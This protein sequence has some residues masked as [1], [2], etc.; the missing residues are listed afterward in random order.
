[1][2]T[3]AYWTAVNRIWSTAT[4]TGP[5]EKTDYIAVYR[6]GVRCY[7]M[8]SNVRHNRR[9]EE[10]GVLLWHT[11]P[12]HTYHAVPLPCCSAK[13]LDC[14]FPIWFT[15]CGRVWFTNTM[16]FPCHV[17]NM[18]FWKRPLNATAGSWQGRGM[19]TAWERHGM[20]ELAS[21]VQ[22]RHAGDLPVFGFFLLPRG[23]P[24]GLLSEAYLSRM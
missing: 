8:T 7:P 14:V 9:H 24:G 21:T 19:G 13:G 22:R 2:E 4:T 23:V 3:S 6:I 17:T 12:I 15:Q 20:C 5:W 1:M 10:A 18:P 11:G 16:P